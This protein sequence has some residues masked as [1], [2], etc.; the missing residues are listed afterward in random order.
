M[1]F[2]HSQFAVIKNEE[3]SKN[4]N[5]NSLKL[6]FASDLYFLGL[7]ENKSHFSALKNQFHEVDKQ[8]TSDESELKISS[9]EIEKKLLLRLELK[10]KKDFIAAD[11]IRKELL[12]AGIAI[13][14]NPGGKSSWHF[15]S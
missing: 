3:N 13:T 4:I 7:Q 6:Q 14:D 1:A 15:F 5:I 8:K 11:Q 12:A 9:E 2:M 10:T